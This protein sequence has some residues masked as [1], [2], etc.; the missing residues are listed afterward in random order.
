[1][2]C[3]HIQYDNV[4]SNWQIVS[5]RR[6]FRCFS[7][8]IKYE[9]LCVCCWRLLLYLELCRVN[10]E[11]AMLVKYSSSFIGGKTTYMVFFYDSYF[12]LGSRAGANSIFELNIT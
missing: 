11:R 2:L 5:L 6:R 7:L 4:Y 8:P 9:E 10:Q 1:M 3:S 12:V